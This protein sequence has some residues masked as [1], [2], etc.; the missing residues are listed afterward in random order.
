MKPKTQFLE[1]VRLIQQSRTKAYQSVNAELIN[2][3]W[4]VGE[5]ISRRIANATWGDRSID[6]LAKFIE[7]DHPDLKGYTR[8]NLYRMRQFYEIYCATQIV[9]PLARQ[10]QHVNNQNTIMVSPLVTPLTD[11]RDTILAQIGWTHHLIIIAR[12]KTPEEREFYMRSCIKERYSK[13][14]LDRQISSGLFERVMLGKHQFPSAIQHP[15]KEALSVFKSDYILEFLQ[16]PADHNESDLQK[17]LVTQMKKFIMELGRDFL[18]MGEE[19]RIQVGNSDFKADLLFFHRGLQCLV[20]VELKAEKFKPEHLGQLNFYLEA[21][22]RD[23]KKEH[24][25]PSIGILLCQDQ[26]TEVVK[27]ALNR[28]MSPTLVAAYQTQLP[29]KNILQQKWKEIFDET[30]V[31]YSMRPTY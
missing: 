6:D 28:S 19:Y 20:V 2:C 31:K 15:K 13:R 7:K 4:Q 1:V 3:Y 23:V 29:D 14:E 10:L 26:D 21:L 22:D 9:A 30:N 25:N 16:L 8:S 11:I 27:Y 12:T 17:A 5:Y 24:E 18:F